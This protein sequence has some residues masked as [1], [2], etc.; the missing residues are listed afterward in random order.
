MKPLMFV[1]GILLGMAAIGTSAEAQNYPWCAHYGGIGGT[2]CGF[3]TNEQC[4]A[5]ISGLGGSCMQ[6]TQ[7]AAPAPTVRHPASPAAAATSH[8]IRQKSHQNLVAPQPQ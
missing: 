8:Q 5:A 3:T 6:N 7:Y 2:N 4:M 1:L